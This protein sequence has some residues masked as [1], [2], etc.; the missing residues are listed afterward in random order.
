MLVLASNAGL[1]Q[2]AAPATS[3]VPSPED[4]FG[5]QVGADY[6][7]A[8]HEQLVDYF[9]KLDAASDRIVVENIGKSTL[10]KPMILAVISSE[11]NIK[12]RA[13]Y[14]DI[15]RRLAITRGVDEAQARALAK[16]GKAIVWIDGGLH[17]T[18]V[19]GAQHTPELAWW[20]V[21]SDSDE[22]KRV[23]ENTILLLMPSMN[24]D[25]LDIVRDWYY[26]NLGTPFET[27]SPPE[28]YHH[29]VGHDNN[30]DWAMFT[31]VETRAV[32]HQLYQEWLPQI[33]YNHHQS[34]PF[35]S[36]IWGPPMK[37]P[38][39]PNLDPLVVSTI[40]QLGEA[41]RKRFDE[42][43]KP[44][45]SSHMLYDIWWNGSMRGGP[46]FHNMAGFLTE[47]SLYRLATPY[48]YSAEEIPETFG[49]R[50][51]NLP[52]KTPSVNYTRPWL[53]GCWPF[54][55]PVEYMI[56]AS[57][58]TLDLAAK[59]KEDFLYNIWRMG[60]RQI[61]RGER[62]EGGPFAYVIDPAAQHDQARMV[63]FLRTFRIAN[64]EVRQAEAAFTA[65]GTSY[66]AGTYVLGPQAFR[67]YVVDL[68]DEK[69]FPERRLYPGGPP[70]PPYDMTGYEL[71]YQ[72]GIKIDRVKEAFPLPA[73][74]VDV[75]ATPA[76]GVSGTAATAYTLSP[77]SNWGVKA[78]NRLLK[79]GA[80]V[81]WAPDNN[82]VVQGIA[83]DIVAK[84]GADLG[85][86][87]TGVDAV[88]AGSRP[89]RA[90]RIGLY[91]SHRANMDEGWTRW[92]LEQH[93]FPYTTLKNADMRTNDFSQFDV[94]LFADEA[95]TTILNGAA[96]GTMPADYVGGIGLEGAANVR[97]FVERG[98]WVVAWDRAADFAI[99][100]LDLPLR[101][102]VKDTR[103]DEFFIPGS[104]LRVTTRPANPLAAGMEVN[105]VAMF[106]DSQAFQIVAPA[107]AGK[108]RAPRDVDVFV[109]YPRQ[110]LLV[111][112]W[113]LGASRYI[114]GRVAAARVAVG[115]GQSVIMGFR[116]HWRGQ[117]H[118]TFKLLFNPLFL[119]TV[120]GGMPATTMA[121]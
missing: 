64:I 30:R 54:R 31:Q 15:A 75:I 12:N 61:A 49:E 96:A 43:E 53:G 68:I 39:N 79:A 104:L 89:I 22:A 121:Q 94:L 55:Q 32:A 47:T 27:T 91:R 58:A 70:D 8:S 81:S 28:L 103:S 38:V 33:V 74:L 90:P 20:L 85:V 67:P 113:E 13:R 69:K 5:F 41:M 118:N 6:K 2:R 77:A 4:V 35:P 110:N 106:S 23:R 87:F 111:S 109:E 101:N 9:T 63:E 112:G 56:T 86:W 34:G 100:A 18:E 95:D 44:G 105:A 17:A 36:R 107:S 73:K 80:K 62:A 59:L 78:I 57:R 60:T 102:T 76:G 37:D 7:L 99:L 11:A 1:A 48:C 84:M 50:H 29:Y 24:P 93:E 40:N 98:G 115:K 97:R 117:P 42:E 14:Q 51:K 72:M 71:S 114:A 82:M 45:Y 52:A 16:E 92:M 88:P 10:G 108:L 26:Q 116:P 66:P 83:R 21:T 25:G 3:K 65:G 120:E 119:S 46:D 19:A